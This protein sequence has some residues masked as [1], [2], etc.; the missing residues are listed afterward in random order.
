MPVP[1]IPGRE[2]DSQRAYELIGR[3]A[4]LC[5]MDSKRYFPVTPSSRDSTF[6]FSP[7]SPAANQS[8]SPKRMSPASK[9]RSQSEPVFSN[10]LCDASRQF[11]GVREIRR[12]PSP[13]LHPARPR[14]PRRLLGTCFIFSVI[15][16]PHNNF[17]P[18]RR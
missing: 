13:L 5:H 8:A 17:V 4:E 12:N 2:V 3:V 14:L 16:C 7:G 9:T 18:V 1:Q 6:Y 10:R 11:L 15:P